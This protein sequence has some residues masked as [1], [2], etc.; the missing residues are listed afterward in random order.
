MHE[1][2]IA[3]ER[4][5]LVVGTRKRG[6]Y[7]EIAVMLLQLFEYAFSQKA[8]IV[9]PPMFLWHET[10]IEE[11]QKADLDGNADIEVCVPIAEKI[12]ETERFRCYE[13]PGGKMAKIR[14]KGPYEASGPAYED[15][16]AW[17]KENGKELAGPIREA[18]L[19]DPREVGPEETLTEIYAPIS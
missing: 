8:R 10:S 7:K 6:H 11:A 19:N 17:M 3:E 12:S 1:I 2:S 16:F 5:R 9:G 4:P 14:H 18:Y 13:L 15:L